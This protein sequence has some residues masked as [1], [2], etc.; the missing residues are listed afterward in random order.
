M[1]KSSTDYTFKWTQASDD[2]D[3]DDDDGYTDHAISVIKAIMI[4]IYFQHGR[5]TVR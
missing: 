2:D 5:L 4:K 1:A 3:D